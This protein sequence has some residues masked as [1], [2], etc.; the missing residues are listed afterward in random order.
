[1]VTQNTDDKKLDLVVYYTFI[2]YYVDK[3]CGR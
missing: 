2:D 3:L 1:M